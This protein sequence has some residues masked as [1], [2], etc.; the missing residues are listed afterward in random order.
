MNDP[1]WAR[2]AIFAKG[3]DTKG[4]AVTKLVL[5]LPIVLKLQAVNRRIIANLADE[6][7]IQ[8]CAVSTHCIF[9]EGTEEDFVRGI[10]HS[11]INSAKGKRKSVSLRF[12]KL[13]LATNFEFLELQTLANWLLKEPLYD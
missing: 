4:E 1:G 11:L 8:N 3:L 6:K 7:G 10:L 5:E 2:S 13:V 9:R 12:D